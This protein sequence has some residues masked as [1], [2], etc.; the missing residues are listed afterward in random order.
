MPIESLQS[1]FGGLL[2]KKAPHLL[3]PHEAVMAENCVIDSG[4]ISPL[5]A[6]ALAATVATGTASIFLFSGAWLSHTSERW[7]TQSDFEGA[8][9]C[10]YADGGIPQKRN[11]AGDEVRLGIE[12][13]EGTI[14]ATPGAAH[15]TLVS[16]LEYAVTYFSDPLLDGWGGESA[17]LQQEVT[18][19]PKLTGI[20]FGSAKNHTPQDTS[21]ELVFGISTDL[22]PTNGYVIVGTTG[23]IIRYAYRESLSSTYLQGCERGALGTMPQ[24]IAASAPVYAYGVSQ[25]TLA[26]VPVSGDPQ[27]TS[28]RLYRLSGN[29][30]R[31][32]GEVPDNT[33]TTHVET[34]QDSDLG[35]I[36]TSDDH[37]PPPNLTGICGPYNGMLIGW[38]DRTLYGTKVGIPDA[39]KELFSFPTEIAAAATFGGYVVVLTQDGVYTVSG[40]DPEGMARH[41]SMSTQ[42]CFHGRTVADGGA[43]LAYLS[44]DGVCLFDGVTSQVISEKLKRS[45][46]TTMTGPKGAFHDGHYFLFFDSNE[47]YP[48]GGCLI[49]DLRGAEPIWRTATETAR[50][51]FRSDVDDRL[52]L[53]M[54]DGSSINEWEAGAAMPWRYWTGDLAFGSLMAEKLLYSATLDCSGDVQL[55]VWIDGQRRHLKLVE[56][57]TRPY[58]MRMAGSCRGRKIQICL[59]GDG[60]V[61]SLEFDHSGLRRSR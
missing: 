3:G 50:S 17:P 54:A 59:S 39:W 14:T 18:F 21:L 28:R 35:R 7:Y 2:T 43:G 42:G 32:S 19:D 6:S 46:F 31:L 11:T 8:L 51:V 38:L 44:P 58:R 40:A 33:A 45:T 27:V 13:P 36:L 37:D 56:S 23:E 24:P 4:R 48:G 53:G 10:Y 22:L 12:A 29:E 26:G 61:N 9:R 52:Y 47:D 34:V 57:P 16:P 20:E 60:T 49:G 41:K 25:V 15:G 1:F 5:R 30:Y 55:E